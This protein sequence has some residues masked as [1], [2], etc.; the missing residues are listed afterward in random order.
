VGSSEFVISE[1]SWLVSG[2]LRCRMPVE[3]ESSCAS[4]APNGEL[5]NGR[6]RPS[7]LSLPV[8]PRWQSGSATL[9]WPTPERFSVSKSHAQ[10]YVTPRVGFQTGNVGV[11]PALCVA[12]QLVAVENADAHKPHCQPLSRAEGVNPP[13]GTPQHNTKRSKAG[14][15]NGIIYSMLT[16]VLNRLPNRGRSRRICSMQS[17]T[18]CSMI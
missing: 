18:C 14:T 1:M 11:S 16:Q 2:G 5:W 3:M 7:I 17:W 9:W 15:K 8:G 12:P 4:P 10:R 6:S 13:S